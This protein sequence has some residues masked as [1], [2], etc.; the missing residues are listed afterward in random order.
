MWN[1]AASSTLPK[2]PASVPVRLLSNLARKHP[3]GFRSA[4]CLCVWCLQTTVATACWSASTSAEV[5]PAGPLFEPGDVA[6]PPS[7]NPDVRRL[8]ESQV[9]LSRRWRATRA[10]VADDAV[11]EPKQRPAVLLRGTA[12]PLRWPAA[13]HRDFQDRGAWQPRQCCEAGS[14]SQRAESG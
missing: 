12:V 13:E 5:G 1:C 6:E 7:S 2:Q 10:P 11:R 14:P 8:S 3:L 9:P 4:C